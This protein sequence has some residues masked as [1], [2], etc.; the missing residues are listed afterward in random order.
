MEEYVYLLLYNP[1]TFESAFATISI[2]RTKKGA[3]QA[4]RKHKLKCYE[5]YLKIKK[6]TKGNRFYEHKFGEDEQWMI[7]K[8]KIED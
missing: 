2:H 1:C 6:A 7:Q 3:Y 5:E 8:Q 4:M